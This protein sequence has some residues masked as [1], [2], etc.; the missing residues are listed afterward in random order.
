[1]RSHET[2]VHTERLGR[3]VVA[4]GQALDLAPNEIDNLILLAKLHDIG[5]IAIPSSLLESR[6]S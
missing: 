4:M 2:Q 1:M 3:L 6:G 5:K